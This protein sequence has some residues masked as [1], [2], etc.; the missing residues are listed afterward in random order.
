MTQ[1]PLDIDGLEFHPVP[2]SWVDA[3][4]AEDAG[5]GRPRLFAVSAAYDGE[6]RQLTVRYVHPDSEAVATIDCPAVS[7]SAEDGVVP[8]E[9]R[10]DGRPWARS[11]VPPTGCPS[12]GVMR[13]PEIDHLDTLWGERLGLGPDG[14]RA[15]ADGGDRDA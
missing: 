15:V 4:T 6:T 14:H 5:S 7:N 8:R 11:L 10:D 1:W 3:P 2:Q 13:A 9:L 12:T